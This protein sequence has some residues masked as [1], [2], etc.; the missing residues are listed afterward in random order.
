MAILLPELCW[1]LEALLDITGIAGRFEVKA[2]EGLLVL[3]SARDVVDVLEFHHT[4][5]QRH[6]KVPDAQLV[7][8][9]ERGQRL[10]SSVFV[11]RR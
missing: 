3:I 11:F 4:A 2:F 10:H 7:L 6:R 1:K 5:Y 9:N 8:H